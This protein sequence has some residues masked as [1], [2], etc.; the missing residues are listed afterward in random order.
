MKHLLYLTIVSSLL[1]SGCS[2]TKIAPPNDDGV[3]TTPINTESPA[4]EEPLEIPS[5]VKL[6]LSNRQ[7]TEVPGDVF[8]QTSL[9]ELNLSGNRLSGALQAE[10]RQLKDLRVLKADNNLMTGVPAEIGQLEKLE[11]LDLANNRLTGLP[12][13]LG[14]LKNLKELNISGN[15]YSELDLNIIK[16][17][18][19]QS[20]I[21]IK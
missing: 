12:Y 8:K 14:N 18:L 9:Q 17:K 3:A 7:L 13:E 19:P 16:E 5:S 6:D 21:I 1:L 20:V 15:N 2:L 4:G 10:I 11:Y